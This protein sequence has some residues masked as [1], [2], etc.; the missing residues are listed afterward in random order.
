MGGKEGVRYSK[1]PE[2]KEDFFIFYFVNFGDK[3]EVIKSEV[4]KE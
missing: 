1:F 3:G 4:T 2:R